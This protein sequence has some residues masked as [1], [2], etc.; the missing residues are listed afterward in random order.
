MVRRIARNGE[1]G[2]AAIDRVMEVDAKSGVNT[3]CIIHLEEAMERTR[4]VNETLQQE[5][6]ASRAEVLELRVRPRAH[7]RHLQNIV[8]Q[9]ADLRVCPRNTLHQ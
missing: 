4:R 6:A 1:Q 9:L 8:R 3:V 5:L 2:R 7:E